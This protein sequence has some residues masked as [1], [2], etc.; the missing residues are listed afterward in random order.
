M[1]QA[2]Q[3]RYRGVLCLHCRQPI[4]LPAAIVRRQAERKNNVSGEGVDVGPRA[5][6]LR[7]RACHGEGLYAESRFIEC[8]GSPRLRATLRNRAVQVHAAAAKAPRISHI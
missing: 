7:C 1:V 2:S 5:F 8:E 3:E 6:A 4:P